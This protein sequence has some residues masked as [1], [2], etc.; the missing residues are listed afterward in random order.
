MKNFSRVLGILFG[1]AGPHTYSKFGQVALPHRAHQNLFT[2]SKTFYVPFFELF[3]LF[4]PIFCLMVKGCILKLVYVQ[5][6]IF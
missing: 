5:G 3:V 4:G 1:S 2:L 6:H